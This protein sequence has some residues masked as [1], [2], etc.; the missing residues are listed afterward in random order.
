MFAMLEIFARCITLE[1]FCEIGPWSLS[2]IHF[3]RS[4]AFMFR[5]LTQRKSMGL[6]PDMLN[7]WFF[8]KG[9]YTQS[10]SLMHF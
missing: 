10:T 9:L 1:L 6:R 5:A 2:Q 3:T 4:H 8:V 7:L